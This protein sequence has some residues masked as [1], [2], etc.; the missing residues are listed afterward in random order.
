M[1]L[2]YKN[3]PH[4]PNKDKVSLTP[5]FFHTY[6]YTK[7][8]ISLTHTDIVFLLCL[9]I[10]SLIINTHTYQFNLINSKYIP[11]LYLQTSNSGDISSPP[12]QPISTKSMYKT[13]PNPNSGLQFKL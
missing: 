3:N 5:G 6:N 8:T 7:F 12:T 4:C 2:K 10:T 9:E 13:N 1:N 11:N